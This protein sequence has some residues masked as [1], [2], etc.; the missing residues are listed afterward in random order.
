[1][2]T[3]IFTD[4]LNLSF[5]DFLALTDRLLNRP[6]NVGDIVQLRNSLAVVTG[7][8]DTYGLVYASTDGYNCS[9]I[10]LD[11]GFN[12]CGTYDEIKPLPL[13][14]ADKAEICRIWPGL[15]STRR[16]IIKNHL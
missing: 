13:S 2:K 3:N 14:A 16:I 15:S 1:M 4:I 5:N 11:F 9:G 12:M 7:Y 10:A 6:F 8:S